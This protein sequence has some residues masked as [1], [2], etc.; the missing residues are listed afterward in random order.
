MFQTVQAGLLIPDKRDPTY[1]IITDVLDDVPTLVELPDTTTLPG[2]ELAAWVGADHVGREL[3]GEIT[4]QRAG[5][6]LLWAFGAERVPY[7]GPIVLTGLH[8]SPFE[9]VQPK[10]M[11]PIAVDAIATVLDD[12]VAVINGGTPQPDLDERYVLQFAE[13]VRQVDT[14]TH[15]SHTLKVTDD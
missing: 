15:W 9:G 11:Q 12:V 4:R 8:R 6:V 5:T 7:A 1:Q 2:G 10:T 3:R 14:M 13:D